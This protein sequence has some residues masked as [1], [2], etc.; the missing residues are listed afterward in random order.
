MKSELK[1]TLCS[2]L[3]AATAFDVFG[4]DNAGELNTCGFQHPLLSIS[5]LHFVARI[6][7]HK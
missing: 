1:E 3:H 6:F 4:I 7:G 2:F 5:I